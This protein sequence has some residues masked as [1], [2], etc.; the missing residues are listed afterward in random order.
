QRSL[1]RNIIDIKFL[2]NVKSEVFIVIDCIENIKVL[3]QKVPQHDFVNINEHL[4]EGAEREQENKTFSKIT[5]AEISKKYKTGTT[6]I[7]SEDKIDVGQFNQ[8]CDKNK[9]SEI[10]HF[11]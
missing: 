4:N 6:I 11:K 2:E 1:S 10:H 7:V 5:L 3:K 8:I 9:E